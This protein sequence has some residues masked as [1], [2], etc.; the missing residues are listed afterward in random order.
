MVSGYCIC[1]FMAVGHDF[2]QS[3]SCSVQGTRIEIFLLILLL[4]LCIIL[5]EI[6]DQIMFC[7]KTKHFFF[8]LR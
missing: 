4:A 6:M 5:E 2:H 7:G 8:S 3:S 1:D